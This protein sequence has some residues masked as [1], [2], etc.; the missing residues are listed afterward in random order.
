MC[1]IRWGRQFLVA[2]VVVAS[3]EAQGGLVKGIEETLRQKG[4]FMV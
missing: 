2:T 3:S 1:R 4:G